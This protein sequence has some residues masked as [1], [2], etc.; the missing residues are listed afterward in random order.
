MWS[1]TPA[2]TR[3]SLR[4]KAGDAAGIDAEYDLADAKNQMPATSRF[5]TLDRAQS[6]LT[7]LYVAFGAKRRDGT[8]DAVRIQRNEW[9]CV[10]VRDRVGSYEAMKSGV[11]FGSDQAELD[12]I[13]YVERLDYLLHRG[14]TVDGSN[15]SPAKSAS[16]AAH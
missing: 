1:F 3:F 9:R 12:S 10:V 15:G 6:F 7:E 14:I 5:A 4:P 13:F 16:G 11:L 2:I 8:I